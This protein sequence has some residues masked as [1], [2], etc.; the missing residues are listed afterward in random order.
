[1]GI[2]AI[3]AVAHWLDGPGMPAEYTTGRNIEAAWGFYYF[4]VSVF[5]FLIPCVVAWWYS[6]F[7]LFGAQSRAYLLLAC[8][9]F[10]FMNGLVY[11]QVWIDPDNAERAMNSFGLYFGE[12]TAMA[13]FFARPIQLAQLLAPALV[14]VTLLWRDNRRRAGALLATAIETEVAS[15]AA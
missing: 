10:G 9:S 7:A 14:G 3:S 5:S 1:M 15:Q 4:A 11:H 6:R 2:F 13:Q 8:L 12:T